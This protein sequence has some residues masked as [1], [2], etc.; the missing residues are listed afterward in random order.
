MP[1]AKK[2]KLDLEDNGPSSTIVRTFDLPGQKVDVK[3]SIFDELQ[4]HV[5][6]T[7]LKP[8]S[9][10]FRRS[11]DSSNKNDDDKNTGNFKYEW[12]TVYDDDGS[13]S[14]VE[15]RN[16]K[17]DISSSNLM[18]RQIKRTQKLHETAFINFIGTFYGK[19]WVIKNTEALQLVTELADYYCALPV[20]SKS[21]HGAF[22]RSPEF[23][24][25]IF[26]SN[27]LTLLNLAFRLRSPEL[28]R[29]CMICLVGRWQDHTCQYPIESQPEMLYNPKLTNRKLNELAIKLHNQ[30]CIKVSATQRQ[31]V[32]HCQVKPNALGIKAK[33]ER[34]YL[35]KMKRRETEKGVYGGQV[36]LPEYFQTF[37]EDSSGIF[38]LAV[39]DILKNELIFNK[40]LRAGDILFPGKTQNDIQAHFLCAEIKDEDLPWDLNETD[41]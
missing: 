30:I 23:S 2:R 32:F 17:H 16:M 1:L 4:I 14:L 24:K 37:G 6:S 39:S 18:P 29:E 10:F 25:R 34:S 22:F 9:A 15:T 19:S 38:A 3:L 11:L 26:F 31:I 35:D 7:V 8:H 41:W 20:V 13:W 28:F 12:A 33:I 40:S 5:H 36:S 27:K 21:L